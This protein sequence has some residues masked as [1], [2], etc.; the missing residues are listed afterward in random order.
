MKYEFSGYKVKNT[1][2]M[3]L[4][5][6]PILGWM[7]PEFRIRAIIRQY[8]CEATFE[9][10]DECVEGLKANIK[11]FRDRFT[12]KHQRE[13]DESLVGLAIEDAL[14]SYR[15]EILDRAREAKK[16]AEREK[17]MREKS[18]EQSRQVLIRIRGG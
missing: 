16:K 12:Q 7:T 2:T 6:I 13:I 5:Q 9:S 14:R 3:K 8:V 11:T 10:Y 18:A 4:W 15:D 17:T 1:P